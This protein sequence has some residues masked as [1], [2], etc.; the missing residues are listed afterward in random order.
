MS[1]YFRW[2]EV[3]ARDDIDDVEAWEGTTRWGN[4]DIYPVPK[5]ERNYGL[6]G[7]YTYFAAGIISVYGFTA[8]SSYVSAGLGTWDTV[9]AICLGSCIAAVNAFLGS[10][11]GIDTA[12]GWTMMNRSTFGLWGAIL[13]VCKTGI[14]SVIFVGPSRHLCLPVFLQANWRFNF[15]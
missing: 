4:H 11:V 1:K 14:A 7:F 12:L 15:L 9:G 2:A 13:P 6:L 10:S 3:K 5:K 8:A